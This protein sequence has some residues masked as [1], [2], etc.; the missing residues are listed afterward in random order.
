[1]NDL[2]LYMFDLFFLHVKDAINLTSDHDQIQISVKSF[3]RILK[4]AYN[5]GYK[6]SRAGLATSISMFENIAKEMKNATPVS[7]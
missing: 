3:K 2:S 4:E 6:E 5:S 1:M 7:E